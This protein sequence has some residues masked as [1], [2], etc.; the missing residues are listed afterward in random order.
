MCVNNNEMVIKRD[1]KILRNQS[2]ATSECFT[3]S[4]IRRN[5]QEIQKRKDILTSRS[6][7]KAKQQ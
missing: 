3:E 5:L 1:R 2:G 6:V 7:I 4:R